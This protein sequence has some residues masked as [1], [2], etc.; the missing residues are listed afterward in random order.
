MADELTATVCGAIQQL[1]HASKAKF[2]LDT[3]LALI[4]AGKCVLYFI[5]QVD[6]ADLAQIRS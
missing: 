2:L 6:L 4:D 1:N 3:A 5:N